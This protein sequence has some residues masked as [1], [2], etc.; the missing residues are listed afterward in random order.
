[1]FKGFWKKVC[2][3]MVIWGLIWTVIGVLYIN[4]AGISALFRDKHYTFVITPDGILRSMRSVA[5][6][7][8]LEVQRE[9]IYQDTVSP[10][11]PGP[12]K[13][14][15][16]KTNISYVVLY[17]LGFDISKI[18]KEDI[19]LGHKGDTITVDIVMPE[20]KIDV[21]IQKW[22]VV[23]EEL[24]IFGTPM[25]SFEASPVFDSMMVYAKRKAKE[26]ID[27]WNKQLI[28]NTQAVLSDLFS[29]VLGKIVLVK[30]AGFKPV[31]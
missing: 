15:G 8:T 24:G 10:L 18:K 29:S 9:Y 27:I 6:L 7:I 30:I 1:M 2:W 22:W 19:K 31:K 11:I 23:S 17:K 25:K 14:G 16:R 5:D 20:P 12:I 21:S 4:R 26:E 13:I 3:F 28:E